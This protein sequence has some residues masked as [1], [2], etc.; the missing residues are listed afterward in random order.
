MK[1]SF[2]FAIL[3]L[4]LAGL[5]ACATTDDQSTS[6]V[7]QSERLTPD[8]LYIARV[9][10]IARRRGIEV[11]WVHPPYAPSSEEIALVD[12]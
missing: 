1:A 11:V 8:E 5:A 4:S 12:E 3:S 6:R 10:Q 2:R 9:E 7:P